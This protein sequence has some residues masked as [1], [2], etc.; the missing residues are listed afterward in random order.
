M[1]A[2]AGQNGVSPS[3]RHPRWSWIRVRGTRKSTQK[4]YSN[5]CFGPLFRVE[6]TALSMNDDEA[7]AKFTVKYRMESESQ[8]EFL[9]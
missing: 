5:P 8:A 9:H 3:N 7:V 4:K 1:R 6:R 2:V